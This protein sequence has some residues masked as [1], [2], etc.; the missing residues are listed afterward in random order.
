VATTYRFRLVPVISDRFI[1]NPFP[2]R[3]VHI[4][5]NGAFSEVSMTSSETL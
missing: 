1:R 5:M 4:S 3:S 2:A